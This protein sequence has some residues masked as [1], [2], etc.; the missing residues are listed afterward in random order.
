VSCSLLWDHI[1]ANVACRRSGRESVTKRKAA[2]GA[3]QRI[4][5][6][7]EGVEEGSWE[8]TC[9]CEPPHAPRDQGAASTEEQRLLDPE[10]QVQDPSDDGISLRDALGSIEP[11]R[12]YRM[13]ALQENEMSLQDALDRI[14]PRKRS[15]EPRSH[16]Y[17]T[18][19]CWGK[20]RA[21]NEGNER[22]R[23]EWG[24]RGRLS[25]ERVVV[26][27]GSRGPVTASSAPTLSAATTALLATPPS[28]PKSFASPHN[29]IPVHKAPSGLL[30]GTRAI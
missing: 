26:E 3:P 18:T 24:R 14:E 19:S 2:H 5:G 20:R 4:K 6:S 9:A 13:V 30:W 8:A 22:E 10:E 27:N 25:G 16:P 7:K 23:R 1:R 15:C 17:Q 12:E 21:H 28:P 11:P 29:P